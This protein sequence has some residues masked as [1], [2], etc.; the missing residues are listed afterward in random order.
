[1]VSKI[2]LAAFAAAAAAAVAASAAA[3]PA[4]PS[5]RVSLPTTAR[6]AAALVKYALYEM[7]AAAGNNR[8]PCSLRT[9][10]RVFS[11]ETSDGHPENHAVVRTMITLKYG[12]AVR[13]FDLR[14]SCDRAAVGSPATCHEAFV[15]DWASFCASHK[16]SRL[17]NDHV[18]VWGRK[19]HA[20]LV[21]LPPVPHVCDGLP[22]FPPPPPPPSPVPSM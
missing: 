5:T 3:S 15:A 6:P 14:S 11:H 8:L 4:H 22:K 7:Q 20:F 9:V 13:K 2:F 17:C 18:P 10:D 16:W 1:M 21:A 19:A 12:D